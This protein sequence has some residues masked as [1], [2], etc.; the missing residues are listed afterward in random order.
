M[1]VGGEVFDGLITLRSYGHHDDETFHAKEHSLPSRRK[2]LIL[3][4]GP[5]VPRVDK[6]EHRSEHVVDLHLTTLRKDAKPDMAIIRRVCTDHI[7]PSM[8]LSEASMHGLMLRLDL[9]NFACEFRCKPG[10]VLEGPSV[11]KTL[12][13]PDIL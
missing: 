12:E 9:E 1:F 6:D 4:G 2:T 3:L 10:C 8:R 13:P 7:A 5:S 11:Q